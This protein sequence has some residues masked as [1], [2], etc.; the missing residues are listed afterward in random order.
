[1]TL[2]TQQRLAVASIGIVTIAAGAGVA[3]RW[4]DYEAHCC[5]TDVGTT[6]L[7]CTGKTCGL[8]VSRR[9]LL[10]RKEHY[11]LITGGSATNDTDHT[12][13]VGVHPSSIN[14]T[15]N[16]SY[17][18]TR[19]LS[20]HLPNNI[21]DDEDLEQWCRTQLAKGW[22]VEFFE[23]TY[24]AKVGA[25]ERKAADAGHRVD[26]TIGSVSMLV[27]HPAGNHTN[28]YA[29]PKKLNL[30]NGQAT[31]VFSYTQAWGDYITDCGDDAARFGRT[32]TE[33]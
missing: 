12:P 20:T 15:V 28:S 31:A 14:H 6:E 32:D 7:K 27:W 23:Q 1:M 16:N 18:M 29:C 25:S 19:E 5:Y 26:I 22:Q 3:V 10:F 17:I 9:P 8:M 2:T 24:Q 13:M 33:L 30:G 4:S 21:E 11:C